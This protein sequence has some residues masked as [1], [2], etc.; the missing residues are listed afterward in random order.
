MGPIWDFD[1]RM[2]MKVRVIILDVT[3]HRYFQVA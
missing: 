3:T 2:I 1:G